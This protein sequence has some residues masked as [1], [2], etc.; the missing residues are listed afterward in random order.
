M[1]HTVSKSSPS[2]SVSAL[3]F[4]SWIKRFIMPA[5]LLMLVLSSCSGK[6]EMAVR[7]DYSTRVAVKMDIPE[8]LSARI[9][10]IGN[11]GASAPLFDVVK[12]RNEF[13]ARKTLL[14]VD[15]SSASK[16]AMT[17]VL[18][19]PNLEELARDTSLTPPGMIRFE[20]VPGAQAQSALRELSIT[21]DKSNAA[22]AF[23]LFPGIDSQLVDSLS[24]PALEEQS[25]T[26][27]EY[28]MN[29][30][31]VI[32][33]KKAMPA[34]DACALEVN[35]TAPKTIVSATGG[36]ATG[37]TFKAKISLFDLLVLEK[38]IVLAVRW[39]N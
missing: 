12:I 9:R 31:N 16:D 38:P 30:E 15:A 36:I 35:L 24:P 27:N 33:G 6:I 39:I 1:K 8:A 13:S 26:A 11:I 21:I 34:F 3:N 37:Q 25:I 28:R 22:R 7:S 10:Q 32:I 18:W 20:T 4:T 14:L 29:L 5:L 2:A 17:A 23:A 19:V